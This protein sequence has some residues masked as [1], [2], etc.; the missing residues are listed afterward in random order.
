MK[1]FLLTVACGVV[2]TATVQAKSTKAV[3]K[4]ATPSAAAP[5]SPAASAPEPSWLQTEIS[6]LEKEIM[7]Q[8][9]ADIRAVQSKKP[10]A[11]K[12]RPSGP[13]QK[14]VRKEQLPAG[15]QKNIGRGAVLPQAVYAQAQ[16]L[17]EVVV[18]KLP[19]PPAG[20]VLVLLD[21]KVLR[22]LEASR[23]VVDVFELK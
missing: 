21:G 2:L 20:T 18:R 16:P 15:W 23:T 4:Q 22:L 7:K 8:H 19:P 17:P 6:P 5:A 1:V 11:D 3:P 12:A 14:A 9:L 10:G 13:A